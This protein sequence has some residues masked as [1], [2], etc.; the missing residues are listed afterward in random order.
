MIIGPILTI[1]ICGAILHLGYKKYKQAD[2]KDRKD[3]IK[4][5]NSNLLEFKTKNKTK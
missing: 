3:I 5:I 2:S 4:G 1:L